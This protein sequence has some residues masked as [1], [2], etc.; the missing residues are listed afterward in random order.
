MGGYFK[1]LRRKIGVAMLV[2]ACA[3]MAVWMRSYSQIYFQFFPYHDR[4]ANTG[5]I[6]TS[7]G[8]LMW[9]VFQY[10]EFPLDVNFKDILADGRLITGNRPGRMTCRLVPF[11]LI[12][13][14]LTVLSA[15][16][17]LSKQDST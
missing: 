12:V 5:Y 13:L 11:W 2:I 1:P 4:D 6:A 16:L 9:G 8:Y 15:W 17:L 10:Y 7:K 3:L 14:P